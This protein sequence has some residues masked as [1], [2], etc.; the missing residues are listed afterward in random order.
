MARNIEALTRE[1]AKQVS[2]PQTHQ[3]RLD[4]LPPALVQ[5]SR[6]KRWVVWRWELTPK[7]KWTKEPYKARNPQQHA[8]SNAPNTWSDYTAAVAACNNN[9]DVDGIGFVLLD[10]DV[11]A[12]DLDKCRSST[13]KLTP[14]ARHYV[15]QAQGLGA[16]VEITVSGTGLRIIGLGAGKQVNRKF[17]EIGEGASSI[18]AYRK[19][20]RFITISGAELG[21]CAKLPNIDLLIDGVIKRYD[22]TQAADESANTDES[23]DDR[24]STNDYQE[25]LERGTISG[26]APAHRGQMFHRLVWNLASRG[27]TLST[28]IALLR[29]HPKGIAA[30]YLK[31]SNRLAKEV[32]RSFDKFAA[33]VPPII[34][35]WNRS[36]AHVLAGSKSAILQEFT[37]AEGYVDFKLLS[38]ASFHEWYA[39]CF[40]KI[41]VDKKGNPVTIETTKYWLVHP[42]RRKY[43]DIGFFP[44]RDVPGYYNLWR[45]FAVKPVKGDCSKFLAHLRDNVC[46]GDDELYTWVITWFA[47]IFQHPGVKCGT[48]LALRGKQGTGKTK[49]G[50]VFASLLGVHFKQVSDPRFVTGKFNSH[51]ISLLMLHAD[52]GFWAGDKK[53]EGKLKDLV[54]GKSHPIEFKGKEAFW[55]NNYVRLLVTGNPDWIV[56]AGFEERRFAT[57]DVGD[58]HQQDHPYF[59]AIDKEMENGGRE[60]LLYH[61]LHEV[62]CSAV[63]LRQIPHTLA[64]V[65]QKLETASTEQGWW[66]DTLRSGVL[67]GDLGNDGKAPAELL[68]DHYIEHAKNKGV[69][70]RVIETALGMFLRKVANGLTGKKESYD[71]YQGV[72]IKSRRGLV[73]QF[74]PLH[75]CR[76]QFAALLNENIEWDEEDNWSCGKP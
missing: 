44:Q 43:Q 31:P 67:P 24:L 7:G 18:E 14:W 38:S 59:A 63:N 34:I 62:D 12:L 10:G 5:L 17:A 27:E 45:G 30:K 16:Y 76:R 39:E 66:L 72:D 40:T 61:L 65:E 23:A 58:A 28:I 42:K 29:Q 8:K 35:K 70:R 6:L 9:V 48:S 3:S 71:V 55:I 60:A 74:P 57:L 41:G 22:K 75:E 13:G 33:H 2:K 26:D 51:M 32:K 68:F 21:T 50:E 49:V 73:Y 20:A 64:L 37:T 54:T 25:L 19:C 56:P 46:Q 47:D 11:A 52:E 69:P 4:A 53:A 15:E 1:P 36:H